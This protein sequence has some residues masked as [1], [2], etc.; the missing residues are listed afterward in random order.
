MTTSNTIKV[1]NGK[2]FAQMTESEK[3][4]IAEKIVSSDIYCNV[5][6][7]VTEMYKLSWFSLDNGESSDY[8]EELQNLMMSYD[9]ETPI[10][11]HIENLDICE[12]RDL[13][14]EL[15]LDKIKEKHHEKLLAEFLELIA[16]GDPSDVSGW[17]GSAASDYLNDVDY[18]QQ[19]ESDVDY[20]NRV[21]HAIKSYFADHDNYSEFVDYINENLDTSEFTENMM[22][23]EIYCEIEGEDE[24]CSDNNLYPEENEVCE[25]W[26]I[27]GWL[28]HQLKERGY[29]VETI[30]CTVIWGR[31]T[32]GQAICLDSVIQEIAF[33]RF[34]EEIDEKIFNAKL[35]AIDV[36]LNQ[37]KENLRPYVKKAIIENV[38]AHS[39]AND[40]MCDNS[41]TG[42]RDDHKK[43]IQRN[44]D[45]VKKLVAD[46]I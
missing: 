45:K 39:L 31:G 38:T 13:L 9:Y 15:D 2:T 16:N 25:H 40:Y 44:I 5:N 6:M 18:D 33:E 27:S 41:L 26:A 43:T 32:T 23:Y 42:D 29:T 28:E 12:F 34:C 22:D 10:R 14:D 35:A 20:I 1:L 3:Q 11:E 30:G 21:K 37:V 7:M 19:D 8:H 46:Y 36:A 4:E 17:F 24:F